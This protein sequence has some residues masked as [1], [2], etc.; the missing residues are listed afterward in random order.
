MKNVIKPI[1]RSVLTPLGVIAAT[2][3]TD[4][5]IDKKMFQSCMTALIISNQEMYNIMKIVKSLA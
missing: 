4:A 3:A 1:V 2:S 5:A